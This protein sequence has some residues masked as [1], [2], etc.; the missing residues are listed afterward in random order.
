MKRFKNL[1]IFTLLTAGLFLNKDV[2][3]QSEAIKSAR[4]EVV[5]S[6][7]EL[8]GAKEEILSPAEKEKREL[9]L[10]KSALQKILTL[11]ILET[12]NIKEKLFSLKDKDIKAE[13]L[14]FREQL[15]ENLDSALERFRE[16]EDSLENDLEL[17]EVEMIAGDLSDW[18]DASYAPESK[19]AIDFIT[20]FQ[21]KSILKTAD[22]RFGKIS[23]ELKKIKSGKQTRQPALNQAAQNLKEARELQDRAMS[24]LATYLPKTEGEATL[25]RETAAEAVDLNAETDTPAQTIRHLVSKSLSKTKEAYKHFLDLNDLVRITAK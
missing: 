2:G 21:N 19:K 13:F 25:E 22:Q 6:L 8:N 4:Q 3:A 5:E 16:T 15:I 9:A 17:S 7:D 18:R 1:I 14:V 11:S 20:V 12:E 24:L 23:A 10:K